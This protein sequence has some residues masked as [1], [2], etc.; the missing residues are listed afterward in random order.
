MT[1]NSSVAASDEG[2]AC[3]PRTGLAGVPR[4]R[5]WGVNSV[6]WQQRVKMRDVQV[7]KVER[8]CMPTLHRSRVDRQALL[9]HV[10]S[11]NSVTAPERLRGWTRAALEGGDAATGAWARTDTTGLPT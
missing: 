5:G 1:M 10:N 3:R 11:D 7:V 6:A 4:T 9:S 8:T 2:T